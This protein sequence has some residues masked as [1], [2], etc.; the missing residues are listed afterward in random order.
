MAIVVVAVV[1]VVE[2]IGEYQRRMFGDYM[3][4][5]LGLDGVDDDND[6]ATNGKGVLRRC[7]VV[8]KRGKCGSRDG[9]RG[10]LFGARRLGEEGF[11]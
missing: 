11:E 4:R 8:G 10:Q 3:I 5:V 6:E 9:L 1:V 7:L 2:Q